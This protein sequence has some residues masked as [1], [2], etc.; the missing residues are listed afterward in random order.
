MFNIS[1]KNYL[2]SIEI[3][4]KERLLLNNADEFCLSNPLIVNNSKLRFWPKQ[5]LLTFHHSFRESE[6]SSGLQENTYNIKK[7]K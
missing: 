7:I 5:L 6:T 1:K 2:S 3:L 4:L